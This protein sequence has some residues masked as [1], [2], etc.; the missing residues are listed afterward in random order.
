MN[1]IRAENNMIFFVF[2][3][4]KFTA[5]VEEYLIRGNWLKV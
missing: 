1:V 5:D 4:D 2:L 3:T